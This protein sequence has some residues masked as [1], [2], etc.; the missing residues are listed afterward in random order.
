MGADAGS[1]TRG[2]GVTAANLIPGGAP[3]APL[4]RDGILPRR[5][6]SILFYGTPQ[7][8]GTFATGRLRDGI[9][10]YAW[11]R[12]PSAP[13]PRGNVARE[14]LLAHSSRPL[15]KTL[16]KRGTPPRDRENGQDAR[17][18]RRKAAFPG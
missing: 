15:G 11:A 14:G 2:G 10:L 3:R 8:R 16:R 13:A 12:P 9:P 1:P 7:R 17:S 5:L 6:S 4:R 18:E